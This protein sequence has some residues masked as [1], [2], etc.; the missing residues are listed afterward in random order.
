MIETQGPFIVEIQSQEPDYRIQRRNLYTLNKR[1]RLRDASD[2][3]G[4]LQAK[5]QSAS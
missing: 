1:L 5:S 2:H 4:S 3:V